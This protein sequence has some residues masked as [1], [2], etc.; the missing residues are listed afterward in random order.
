MP[1]HFGCGA[2][3]GVC[4]TFLA[5]A[6]GTAGGAQNRRPERRPRGS[7]GQARSTVMRSSVL[8]GERDRTCTALCVLDRTN[9]V[10][11]PRLFGEPLGDHEHGLSA[12]SAHVVDRGDWLTSQRPRWEQTEPD[13]RPEVRAGWG[14][15]LPNRCRPKPRSHPLAS[16]RRT[17]RDGFLAGTA[18][19]Q[20]SLRAAT[21]RCA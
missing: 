15:A 11:A 14:S 8:V 7:H 18:R 13:S 19:H 12:I 2:R 20:P 16:P 3:Q 5:R 4:A 21:N 9:F 17:E 10:F 6:R 1:L